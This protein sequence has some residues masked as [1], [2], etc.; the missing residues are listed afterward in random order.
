MTV[1][2]WVG[3]DWETDREMTVNGTRIEQGATVKV[4]GE[5]GSFFRFDR[6]VLRP[7][8]VE[9]VDVTEYQSLGQEGGKFGAVPVETPR[10][11]RQLVPAHQRSFRPDRI[12]PVIIRQ[13]V[14]QCTVCGA[15][16]AGRKGNA[17]TCS[18]K[19]RQRAHQE[20]KKA[21]VSAS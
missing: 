17:R 16:L 10:G 12:R 18:L 11:R 6:Y 14:T 19:C 13:R 9:W 21:Q 3:L 8:G 4:K 1:A 5:Q 15:S 7:S 2:D 20:K